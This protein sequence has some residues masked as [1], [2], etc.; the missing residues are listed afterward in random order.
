MGRCLL[1]LRY[2]KGQFV[3]AALSSL[4]EDDRNQVKAEGSRPV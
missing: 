1:L 4:F 3:E 2:L